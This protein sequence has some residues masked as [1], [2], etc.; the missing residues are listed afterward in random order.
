MTHHLDHPVIDGLAMGVAAMFLA[1]ACTAWA[2]A[3]RYFGP[4][5]T[6]R[7]DRSNTR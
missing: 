6:R 2:F 1:A 5:R 4:S 7:H 3:Y